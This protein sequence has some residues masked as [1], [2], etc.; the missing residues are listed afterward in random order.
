MRNHMFS[1]R[2]AI[3]I[4]LFLCL[5][6]FLT[7]SRLFGPAASTTINFEEAGW[8]GSTFSNFTGSTSF[9]NATAG[10]TIDLVGSGALRYRVTGAS[11]NV[12]LDLGS[13]GGTYTSHSIKSNDGAAFNMTSLSLRVV[14]AAEDGMTTT[15]TAKKS[16]ATVGS[17]TAAVARASTSVI[18]LSAATGFDDVD[19]VVITG[20]TL[21]IRIFEFATGVAPSANAAPTSS[22]AS[23]SPSENLTFTFASSDFP[24][25]DGDGDPI[26]SVKIESL[27]GAGTLY[28]DADNDD[29][30]DGGEEVSVSD[31]IAI[32]DINSGNLQYIQNGTTG[33]SF[34]FEVS[35]GTDESTGNY[36]MTVTMKAVPTVT[37]SLTPT[38]KM[39]SLTTT[40]IVTATLSNDYGAA[41]LVNLGFSGTATGSGVDYSA[42]ANSITVGVGN[43]TNS[44]LLTNVP[45]ALYE[46]NET[47]IIDITGVT[48]GVESGTQQRTF[49]I[50]DDDSQPNATLEVLGIYNPITDESGGQA[51]VRAVIDAV[52]GTTITVPLSFSGTAS[53]GGTDYSVT[54]TSIIL[55]PGETMDSIRITSQYDGIEEGSET[56][57]VDMGTPTNAV[58]SGTQQVTVTIQD[59]DATYPSTSITSGVPAITN[60]SPFSVTI[61]F[62]ESVTGFTV[63]DIS[64]GNGSASNFAGT[65]TTYT[66]DIT[67]SGEGAV[68]VNVAADVAVDGFGNGNTAATQLSRTY[69]I[70]SP[71]ATIT[72][73][74]S[75]PTNS[76]P[77][78]VTF[79]F[80]ES[81]TGFALGD[82]LVG[83]GAASNLA[84]SGDTYT[85]DITPSGDGT[86]TVDVNAGVATD[87][88][89]NGNTAATQ[90]SL[91][92][93]G[94]GPTTTITTGASDPTNSSPFSVTFTFSESVTGFA[95]GDIV[96]GNGAASNLAGSG[97]TYTADITPSGDG[98]VTVDVNA[99]VAIDG[100]GN[101][102]TAASQLSL[103]YD[104]TGPTTAIATAASNPTSTSPIPVTITF[105]ESVT[106]FVI[107]DIV[108]G[109]GSASNFAGSGDTYTVDITPS[110][111]GTVTVDVG[112]AVAVDGAG[113]SNSAATQ[114]SRTYDATPPSL[115]ITTGAGDPTSS[116]PFSVTF[117]FSE[118][119]TGF[120]IGDIVVGNGSASNFAGSGDTYTADIT[121]SGD[122]TVTVDV[123]AAVAIDGVGNNN[124]AATQL[125]LTFD[126]TSPTTSITSGASDPTNSSPFSVTINFSES[127]TGFALGDISVGNGSASNLAGSGDTY[128][129]D[130]TPAGDGSVT[131][132]VNAGVATD[133]AGNGNSA[134]TQFSLTY[135]GSSP[136]LT[137]TT[138]ASN[139]T[140]SSPFS[141]TFTFSESVTGFTIGDIVVGNGS[142]S[143]FAGSGD[144]YTADI[145]PASDGTVT[146]DVGAAV[147][148]DGSG[149]SNTA[150]TQLSRTY[151]VTGPSVNI[152]TGA[153]DPTNSSPFSVTFTFSE[154]VTGFALGDITVGNGSA[155]NLAGS[156][157]TYTADIT[158][159][160]DGT[161]TVDVNA[162]VAADAAGN[163]NSAA[164]QLS[165]TYDGT[166]PTVAISTGASNP[167]NSSP[168]SVTITFSESVTGFAL[169]DISVGNGAASNLA[170]SG[171][172]YTADITPAGDGSVTVDVGAA[173]AVDGSGNSNSAATQLSR[174]YDATGPTVS[175]TTGAT[176]PTNSSPFSVTFTFSESVTGFAIGDISVGNG[177]ASNLAGSGDTYT[178][179]ITPAADGTVTVDVN[180]GVAA[181]AASNTNSAAVQLSLVSDRTAPS[182]PTVAIDML[183]E[184][185][186]NVINE[187]IIEFSGSGLEVGTTLYYSFTSDGGGTPVT[188]TETVTAASET[189][190]N[191]GSGYD[192]SGLT[193]GT[194]TLTV[195]L[196]DAAGNTSGNATD[197]ETKDAGPP[198][199]YT[200]A[201]DDA[202]IGAAEATA[203]TFTVSNAEVGTT[204]NYSITSSGD[205]NTATVNSTQ[206][207]ST[208]TQQVMVDVSSLT[209]G[210]L[211]VE[212]SLTDG[213][214]NTGGTQSD[215]SAVLDQTAPAAFT[216][217]MDDA[218]I[219]ATEAT[220]ISFTFAG[221][222]VGA[223]FD[224]TITSDGGA[225][226]VTGSGTT[227]TAGD[228]ITSID[229]SSLPDGNL[230]LSVT[231][232]DDAGNGTVASDPNAD[233]DQTAP[234]FASA[235][236][237][238][239]DN[240]Y[241]SGE[242]LTLVVDLGEAG[243][244]VTVDASVINSGFGAAATLTDNTDGTYTVSFADVDA[245]GNMQEGAAI[246]VT[247][248]ATDGFGNSNTD[249]SLTLD[250]DKTAPTG[251]TVAFDAL[252]YNN[253]NESSASFTFAGAEVGTTYDYTIT[254][255]GGAGTVTG[256]GTVSGAGATVSGI[257]V[258]GL[259]DGNLT[260][261]VTLTDNAGNAGSAAT[262]PGSDKDTSAPAFVSVTQSGDG[263][264][265]TGEG[266]TITADL[267]ETG[268]TVTADLS[269][270]N[271]AFSSAQAFTDNADGTY[272]FTIADVDAGGTM[273]EG[274]NIAIT[275]SATDGAG[276]T[277]TDNSLLVNLDKSA[278]T[279]FT[280]T[281]DAPIN[282]ANET[283][284]S[285]T[286]AGAEVDAAYSYTISSDG[287]GTNVT[288]GGTI[289]TATDQVANIDVSGL[290]DGT[291]TLSVILTDTL[292]NASTAATD[293]E[294]KDTQAPAGYTVAFDQ[295]VYTSVDAATASFTF[296]AAEVG[297]AYIY[298]ISS[299]GGGTNVTG[300]GTIATATDQVSGVDIS[301]LGDGTVTVSVVL[302]DVAGNAGS[303]AT[304]DALLDSGAPTGY[305]VSFDQTLVTSSNATAVS[306]TFAAAEIGT[307][308][309]YTISSSGGGTNVTGSGTIASA[310][311]QIT[312]IDVSGLNIGTL[313]LTVT[314]TD[315]GGNTGT[316]ATDTVQKIDAPTAVTV[317]AN[318]V[319]STGA[320]LNGTVNGQGAA[321]TIVT[322]VYAD[323]INLTGSTSIQAAQSPLNT[324]TDESVSV[325][326]SGLAP[327][328]TY[329]F[330]V[331]ANNGDGPDVSG[332]TLTFTTSESLTPVLT[333][334]ALTT[335]EDVA[336][337]ITA[338]DFEGGF[339]VS[340]SA[341]LNSVRIVTLPANGTLDVGGTAVSTGQDIS[342]GDL[343]NLNYT[344]N[345]DFNGADSFTWNAESEGIYADA[346]ATANIT[347][348]PVN[349]AP[350]ISAIAN[351]T[352]DEG[353]T[354]ADVA[355][356][357]GDVDNDLGTLTLTF[358]SSDAAVVDAN[359][360]TATGSGA[361]RTLSLPLLAA[362]TTDITVT[363]SDGT[364]EASATFT[365]TVEVPGGPPFI[366]NLFTPNGDGFNDTW[367]ITNLEFTQS[368]RVV[369]FESDTKKVVFDIGSTSPSGNIT[370]WDGTLDGTPVADGPYRYVIEYTIDGV[371]ERRQGAVIVKRSLED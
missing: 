117:S 19:E 371:T 4:V 69:D 118:S 251:Y 187:S 184:F 43:T 150:A 137:I 178:A 269:V 355:F 56:V 27:P 97:D 294:S 47:I 136:S 234:A 114:L 233:L 278:P 273:L 227:I 98:T 230:T 156:G 344:P 283:A 165:L 22:A 20:P 347:V 218:Q 332:D 158:P 226:S 329:F 68:T 161:V 302:T 138:G 105:S 55:T 254:S 145:T 113:N 108:V 85:A 202:L 10:I 238:G 320:T 258:S 289:A 305:S 204:I 157:D 37:L 240:S 268:L 317:A 213:G 266:F 335:D 154:S 36:A 155:S 77:F 49:T 274:V 328:T 130:I 336:L 325:V 276:N 237:N 284:A 38:S 298:T 146:I 253:T 326:I 231:L 314:L 110:S 106:G 6:S 367:L 152:T 321:S 244:T 323:N 177:S 111:D 306:F 175:I 17:T 115:S 88:A 21:G 322:F 331:W 348:N 241:K 40:S 245:G 181:D 301:G 346:D 12:F 125:S 171:D 185:Q 58:E 62:G 168:F 349:D 167:T 362:G 147:A 1:A 183:G 116:S 172:T 272:S 107:G 52:A 255:D 82:I 50:V 361:A 260:L 48:N 221:A 248:T 264:Y 78:S 29:V 279:G 365:V 200:V 357:L 81:V 90:L 311:D 173:V 247:F 212:I 93:D 209:D 163:T 222:Q 275:V 104:G 174:T 91:T 189:F 220:A 235:D 287:G 26:S 128:T 334:I 67:P 224:Y 270:I 223:S 206:A 96:V 71:T 131:V 13:A 140:N 76:S 164:T 59:E 316:D 135:D 219:N 75:D 170:G 205:G 211:T 309:N 304:D 23:V 308:Y 261:S 249:N 286:F 148:V 127:V 153:S 129:A 28:L 101:G 44:I 182:T 203:T 7:S 166:G 63:G 292:G 324:A 169:G 354:L 236:D 353:T 351:Q 291:L 242:T 143:N 188:G 208:A 356:T 3:L 180:A 73:G 124:T 70:T 133:A 100:A 162:G 24:Y 256:S 210:T 5:S 66:A 265:T 139:P 288:G 215:N 45:D 360:I 102:N 282:A 94:T 192:L 342:A 312:N 277:T 64:V 214:G 11:P 160:A 285:F 65:G 83:N 15:F 141:V 252:L 151:D 229:I 72:T 232:S 149:N 57:I 195:Y 8:P 239:G 352:G 95:L 61:T 120:A 271:S 297:A 194:I 368:Y 39:E 293:T 318:S 54:G 366:P 315:G 46:G 345:A 144:T 31:F 339:T 34:Q 14:N 257:D 176:D 60:S 41:V 84:G 103:T 87:A 243:L 350:T 201:W 340:N 35:D 191:S 337:A 190:N 303:A 196:E 186:I 267:G 333:D 299:T 327:A 80:S 25:S 228:Q 217:S 42:S 310:T 179:D 112:A 119:V 370:Y 358:V 295:A 2:G 53:G 126:G 363:V 159:A 341:A 79:T 280:V 132:D 259:P 16:G 319:T 199:G 330:T 359:Q 313:T 9:T 263:T 250:L 300:S 216:V 343:A 89:G 207:V 197:S 225:G 109:N 134:A 307:T 281:I 198:V 122:G 92:Y 51:Y 142:A 123:G 369:A 338:A 99:G 32:A 121:P 33:T 193:D 262:D 296:A 364:D 86:V 246:A 74:A 290:A 18:N 30:Y